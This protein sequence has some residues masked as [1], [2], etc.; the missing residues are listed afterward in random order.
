MKTLKPRFFVVFFV[1]FFFVCLFLYK[2]LDVFIFEAHNKTK[3][4][5]GTTTVF[6]VFCSHCCEGK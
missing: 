2:A 3:K 5:Y 4:R 1:S 6:S